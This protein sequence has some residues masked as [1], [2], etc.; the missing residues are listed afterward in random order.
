LPIP[1][2]TPTFSPTPTPTVNPRCQALI[3]GCKASA[4]YQSCLQQIGCKGPGAMNSASCQNSI[5][6]CDKKL[7]N[8]FVFYSTYECP[9]A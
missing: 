1:S 9:L 5:A 2:P 7:R 6:A 8:C 4:P 3:D